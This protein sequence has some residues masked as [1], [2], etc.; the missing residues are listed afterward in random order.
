MSHQVE[1][2]LQAGFDDC[3]T[4][5]LQLD[6]LQGALAKLIA[7]RGRRSQPARGGVIPLRATS[8]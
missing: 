3:L 1:A 5:P 6:R 2:Y 8:G 4:K 7:E